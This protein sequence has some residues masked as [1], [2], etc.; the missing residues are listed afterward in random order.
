LRMQGSTGP[1]QFAARARSATEAADGVAFPNGMVVRPDNATLI[2]AESYGNKLTALD[3]ASRTGVACA[4]ATAARS[5]RRA[6][7]SA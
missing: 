2:L 7:V 6:R 1:I 3:I 4:F 5:C